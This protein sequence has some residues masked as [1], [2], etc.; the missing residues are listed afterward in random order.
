MLFLQDS[1]CLRARE[2]AQLVMFLLDKNRDLSSI[3]CSHI[4]ARHSVCSC[5]A[6]VEEIETSGF[7][8]D[9]WLTSLAE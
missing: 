8:P 1:G 9:H 7:L 5:N 4:K 2:I 3:P 6:G